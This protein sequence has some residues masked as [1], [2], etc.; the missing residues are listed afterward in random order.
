[1]DYPKVEL[2]C[3]MD[4]AIPARLF[5]KYCREDGL[6]PEGM[7]DEQWL[8]NNVMS[9]TMSLSEC[10][11][12]FAILTGILQSKER[13]E[14]LTY[15]L[16]KDMYESGTKLVE[17]RFSPQS[18]MNENLSM[19]EAVEAVL[20]G[21]KK[22]QEVY[23]DLVSGIIVCMMNLG[24]NLGTVENNFLTVELAAKY[25]DQG[26]VGLDLAGDECATPIEDYAPQFA[27][28]RKLG[29]RFTIHAGESGSAG[30]VAFAISQGGNRIGHGIHAI[31]DDAVVEELVKKGILLE[32]STT[33]NYY[34]RCVPSLEQHP[35]RELWDRGVKINI[36]TD[37][38]FLMDITLKHEY[39]LLQEMFGFTEKEFILSNLYSAQASFCEGK[40]KIIEELQ[41]AYD[42]CQ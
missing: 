23:P 16:L 5:V 41:T 22:A 7:S 6:V 25:K 1:M 15:E 36:N 13:L 8:K 32:V 2:H 31:E 42:N 28:A 4:G 30:N 21:R 27:L 40:E 14:E 34:S 38:P 26:V 3:H 10:M 9:S 19:E 37:D 12:L 20:R 29:V 11:G 24:L 17:L 39:D 33:S 35:I 18:H